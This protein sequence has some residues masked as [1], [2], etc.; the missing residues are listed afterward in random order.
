M[1]SF[2]KSIYLFPRDYKPE[3]VFT[4]IALMILVSLILATLFL[5]AYLYLIKFGFAAPI[6]SQT[7]EFFKIV[8][9]ILLYLV[10]SGWIMTFGIGLFVCI[11]PWMMIYGFTWRNIWFDILH[12]ISLF[13]IIYPWARL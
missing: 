7:M 13:I 11:A 9:G 3:S 2:M 8:P 12:L 4:S 6:T 1:K 10:Y 5:T